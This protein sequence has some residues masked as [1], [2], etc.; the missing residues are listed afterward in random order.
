MGKDDHCTV[1]THGGGEL[2]TAPY[3]P[4]GG[5]EIGGR[6]AVATGGGV[7]GGGFGLEGFAIG[8]IGAGILNSLTTKTNIE[9]IVSVETEAWQV[10]VFSDKVTPDKL[11]IELAPAFGH[12]KAAHRDARQASE[13]PHARDPVEQLA[14]LAR[15]R[16]GGALTDE[17]FAEA[18]QKLLGEM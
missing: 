12:I 6:G 16:E 13:V 10:I 18:K 14:E 11:R 7:I 4:D 2:L 15:L 9:T 5:I 8:A 17:E 1:L 3:G